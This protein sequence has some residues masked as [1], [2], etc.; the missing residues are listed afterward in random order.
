MSGGT[1]YMAPS[2]RA[3]D[4]REAV[5]PSQDDRLGMEEVTD[6]DPYGLGA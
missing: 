5:Q 3:L 2:G 4:D 6:E 1:H